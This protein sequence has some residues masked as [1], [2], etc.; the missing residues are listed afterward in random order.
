M[1]RVVV[2]ALAVLLAA[3]AAGRGSATQKSSE[4][5]I[6]QLKAQVASLQSQV[7]SLKSQI[8]TLQ[9]K[10]NNIAYATEANFY[11]DTCLAA[12]TTDALAGSWRLT[13]QLAQATGNSPLFGVQTRI[14]D[15]GACEA[16]R[17]NA[18]VRQDKPDLPVFQTLISWLLPDTSMHLYR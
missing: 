9:Q 17:P 7:R 2:V 13:D 14:N 10:Q 16:L 4:N 1:T 12:L 11:G 3:V 15:K 8:K 18:V 5:D 6:S